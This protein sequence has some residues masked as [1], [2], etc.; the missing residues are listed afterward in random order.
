MRNTDRQRNFIRYLEDTVGDSSNKDQTVLAD[1]KKKKKKTDYNLNILF[2]LDT[3]IFF[4]F[5]L[6][7]DKTR[8]HWKYNFFFLIVFNHGAQFENRWS[9]FCV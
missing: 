8:V 9:M 3:S 1:L 2:E 5:P 7:V 4:P 6:I